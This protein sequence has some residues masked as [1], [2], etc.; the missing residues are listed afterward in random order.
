MRPWRVGRKVG[1][2]IYDGDKLIGMM[3][4]RELAELVV[5]HVNNGILGSRKILGLLQVLEK[6]R[7][8]HERALD[9]CRALKAKL[10]ARKGK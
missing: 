6:A 5:R 1:R 7:I 4:T 3:D 2:T 9:E 10:K 8:D